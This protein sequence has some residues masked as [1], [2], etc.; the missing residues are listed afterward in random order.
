MDRN[1]ILAFLLSFL[2]LSL[3]SLWMGERKPA[4]HPEGQPPI[5]QGASPEARAPSGE[6]STYPELPAAPTPAA[7][8]PELPGE[9]AAEAE[10]TQVHARHVDL[11]LP[12]YRARM[13]TAG[14]VIES[15]DLADYTDH[16][17]AR[18]AMVP[19]DGPAT[20]IAVT[21]FRELG[22]GDLSRASWE[23]ERSDTKQ[24]V[25]RF[26][27]DGVTIRKTYSFAPESYDFRLAI[28]VANQSKASISPRFLV[29]WPAEVRPREQDFRDQSLAA[30]HGGSITLQP[31]AGFGSPGLIGTLFGRQ[32]VREVPMAGDVDWVGF[33]TTY[34]L[35]ALFPDNPNQA[36]ARFVV[37]MPA[38]AGAAQLFFDPVELTPG[39]TIERDFRGYLGPKEVDRLTAMGG[40]AERAIDRGYTWVSPLTRLFAWLLHALYTVI[41]NYGV[42]IILLTLLVRVVTAPLTVRQMRSMERLRRV[43]PRMKEIQEKY[44]EDR[45]KQSEE[46]MKLYKQEKVNPLGGCFPMLLQLPV[47][48][49]LFY[50]LRSSLE[51]R[52]APFVGWINDLSAPDLLFTLPGLNLPVHVLP[53]VMGVT[54]FV[55]QKFTPM[56]TP[57]PTQA[58][59]MMVVMPVMMTVLFYQFPSGLV[60]YWMLS[61]VLAI[62]NQLW[63]GRRMG[64]PGRAVQAAA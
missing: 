40:G 42:A 47:F 19:P 5:A 23:I 35:A 39:Q 8:A 6:P 59:M 56:Q 10:A 21:P 54:M 63:I 34:F 29:D 45:Q 33:Q 60:L 62:L 37:L 57:D 15:W 48:I 49:G 55:Q 44:A 3:W 27:R 28:E 11:T 26:A 46:L 1:L 64:P 4:P 25:F 41:P 2:V 30:L 31:L 20:S 58:R 18:V 14:G 52:H 9:P 22:L 38:M 36:R 50:A 12:L 24:V 53:I 7:P 16:G 43:Q 17:G 61:N 13:S 32:P 51:L